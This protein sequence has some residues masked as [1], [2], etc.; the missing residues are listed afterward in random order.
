MYKTITIVENTFRLYIY[1]F[2]DMPTYLRITIWRAMLIFFM[3]LPLSGQAWGDERVSNN[4]LNLA[5]SA[6]PTSMNRSDLEFGIDSFKNLEKYGYFE[7][8]T[9]F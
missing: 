4:P 1:I 5:R 6:V 2:K 8:T 3:R 9:L 7:F